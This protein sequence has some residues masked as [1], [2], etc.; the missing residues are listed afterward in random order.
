MKKRVETHKTGSSDWKNGKKNCCFYN[1][2]PISFS[3]TLYSEPK[4]QK[5]HIQQKQKY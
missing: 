3:K 4:N 1:R 2:I 5:N